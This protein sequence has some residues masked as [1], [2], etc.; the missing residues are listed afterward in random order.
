MGKNITVCV[1]TYEIIQVKMRME[2]I[3]KT[4]TVLNILHISK[5]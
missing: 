4:E 1:I 5:I 2:K 3:Y